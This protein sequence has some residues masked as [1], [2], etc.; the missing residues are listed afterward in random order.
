M[1]A[2]VINEV[3]IDGQTVKDEFIELFN[4][5]N[6]DIDLAG[7]FLKK[8]TSGGTEK[9]LVSSGKFTGIIPAL[10][11][12][13][14][15]PEVNDDETPNYMGAVTPNLYYSVK[16]ES[17]AKD[18]TVLLYNKD[19]ILQDKVG[20]GLAQDFETMPALNPA[21]FES[22]IRTGGVDTN[23]NSVDFVISKIPTPWTN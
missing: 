18:N 16:S 10:G 5:N 1:Q 20:F 3:Q 23:D 7:F 14:I 6:Y 19:D 15:A 22:V 11:Y 12:F 9:N 2:V 17:V 4:P 13:L 8:K 21:E